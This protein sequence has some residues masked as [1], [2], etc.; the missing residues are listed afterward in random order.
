M[1]K[2]ITVFTLA[3]F[4]CLTLSGCQNL[5]E[6][7][8][9][10]PQ[11]KPSA[12]I[13][14]IGEVPTRTVVPTTQVPVDTPV[15]STTTPASVE[16]IICGEVF[17]QA[18]WESWLER[19]IGPLHHNR[20][21]PTY[22]Y[23]GTQMGALDPHRGVEFLNPAGTPVLAAASGEVVFA[24]TDE[25]ILFGPYN[26]FY[27]KVVIL[28]HPGIY[29][30]RD[31]FTLYAH[32]SEIA[33]EEG[34]AVMVGDRLG[35]VGLSGVAYGAH[36]HFEVRLDYN[37]Y[38]HTTNPILWFEPLSTP[39]FGE[40]ATLAGLVLDRHGNPVTE[41]SLSLKKIDDDDAFTNT[42]YPEIYFP[43]G[44][45]S[46]PL[47]GENFVMADIPPGEYRLEFVFN[48]LQEVSFNL[49]PGSLGFI[50]LQM[51]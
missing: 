50:K 42:Y 33:V 31:L 51:D 40:M 39:D 8:Q 28:H 1:H 7:L 12:T 45:N 35:S 10:T 37:D 38:D 47:L 30:G 14:P 49:E 23:G 24:G 22:P 46:H 2:S 32:L 3:I 19:P 29:D 17:C 9:E 41:L 25:A 18:D 13:E 6:G 44:M 36:L 48:G 21:D 27:G 15:V 5:D 11:T 43:T 26:G 34:M 16:S 20:I 4:L